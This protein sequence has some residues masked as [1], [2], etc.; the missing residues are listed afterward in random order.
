MDGGKRPVHEHVRQV[1]HAVERMGG[2]ANTA[3]IISYVGPIDANIAQ[4]AQRCVEHGLLKRVGKEDVGAPFPANV[5]RL[6]G[7]GERYS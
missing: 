3:E 4:P 6:T 7:K 1:L 5:Y 2:R